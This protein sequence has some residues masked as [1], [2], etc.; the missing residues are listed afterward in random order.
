MAQRT[1]I[2]IE[3][4]EVW[5]VHKLP[6]QE[7]GTLNPQAWCQFCETRVELVTPDEAAALTGKSLREIFRQIEQMEFH[8]LETPTGGVMLC[9]PSL[10]YQI[11]TVA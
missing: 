4:R 1:E 7:K 3:T 11:T 6:E 5:V 10:L 9:L 2:T 8:F